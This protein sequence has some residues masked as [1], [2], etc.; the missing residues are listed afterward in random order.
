MAFFEEPIRYEKMTRSDLQGA[1]RNLR[2]AVAENHP[3]PHLSV[4]RPCSVAVD[5]DPLRSDRC[6]E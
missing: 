2:Q 3:Q 6:D 1:W 4:Y 5:H